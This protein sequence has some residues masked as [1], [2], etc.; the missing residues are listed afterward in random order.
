[1][2][3]DPLCHLHHKLTTILPSIMI[4]DLNNIPIQFG[5]TEKDIYG[6]D[7]EHNVPQAEGNRI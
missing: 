4:G 3:T 1:M 6:T 7:Q 2:N 5:L